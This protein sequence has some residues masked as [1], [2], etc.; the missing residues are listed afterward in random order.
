[1]NIIDCLKIFL[2]PLILVL[3]PGIPIDLFKTYLLGLIQDDRYFSVL[4]FSRRSKHKRWRIRTI[5]QYDINWT[6]IMYHLAK[7]FLLNQDWYLIIDGSPLKEPNAE[8]R[9]TKHGRVHIKGMKNVPY[10]ELISLILTNGVVRI[11]LDKRIWVSP[12]VSKPYDYVTK[13]DLAFNLIMKFNLKNLPVKRIVFDN[14]FANK[15]IMM[16]LNER[17]YTWN[18][19]LK[20]NTILII[21]YRKHRIDQ[22]GLKV[23]ASCKGKLNN[24]GTEVKVIK[25]KYDKK[26]IFVATNDIKR[27]NSDIESDYKARWLTEEFYRDAKQ[28]LGLEKVQM[29]SYKALVNHVGFVCLAYSLLSALKVSKKHKIGDI[30]RAIQ[31]ELYSTHDAIDRFTQKIA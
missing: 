25:I 2:N 20:R 17:G 8:Y 12:K 26:E 4:G 3:Y 29:Q 11:V 1:M 24:T 28:L 14:G 21:K 27:K 22:L 18:T 16:W 30:K 10:N 7:M 5:L 13:P 19:R 31:D 23:G 15:K 6:T 9:T